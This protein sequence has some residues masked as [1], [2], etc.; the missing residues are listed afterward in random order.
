[1]RVIRTVSTGA[2]QLIV[3]SKRSRTV[4]EDCVTSIVKAA[5]QVVVVTLP[6]LVVYKVAGAEYLG[7]IKVATVDGLTKR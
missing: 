3:L 1:V 5:L 2:L 6:L 4:Q 7:S